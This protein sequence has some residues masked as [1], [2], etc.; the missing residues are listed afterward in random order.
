LLAFPFGRCASLER[1]LGR[2]SRQL[3][4][5]VASG[6]IKGELETHAIA[7]SVAIRTTIKAI[8]IEQFGD[9]GE[10]FG[11]RFRMLHVASVSRGAAGINCEDLKSLRKLLQHARHESD[12]F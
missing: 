6:T 4:Q 9:N 12:R 7:A 5:S 2:P 3:K 1:Q 11:W 8:M 10:N